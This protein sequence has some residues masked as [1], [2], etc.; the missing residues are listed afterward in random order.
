MMFLAL[1]AQAPEAIP[2]RKAFWETQ[3]TFL[4]KRR[5]LNSY[6]FQIQM[7]IWGA[8]GWTALPAVPF[9]LGVLLCSEGVAFS[10][11]KALP[12]DFSILI[13]LPEPTG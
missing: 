1:P 2:L 11:Q 5:A 3:F 12:P 6:L 13:S 7:Y 9:F 8:E 10:S 4:L